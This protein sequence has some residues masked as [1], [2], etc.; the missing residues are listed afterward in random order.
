M[1]SDPNFMCSGL[2]TVAPFFGYLVFQFLPL[3]VLCLSFALFYQ[4]MPN[5]R[6][7]WQASLVGG[8]VGGTLWQLNNLLSVFYASRVVS[9]S[10]VYGSLGLVP[11]IMIG[12]YLSW[13]ILLFGAQVAY[14]FQNRRVY[15]QEKQLQ[16]FN[17]AGR[18][19]IGLRIMILA[20][21]AFQTGKISASTA[22][23]AEALGVPTQLTTQ[24]VQQLLEAGMLSQVNQ[25][26]TGFVPARPLADISCFDII[27][28]LRVGTG[29]D[30]L[31]D[32]DPLTDGNSLREELTKVRG[33]EL[34]VAGKMTLTQLASLQG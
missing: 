16:N 27:Q 5:T 9:N 20:A 31:K 1:P 3:V 19:F 25:A 30:P 21:R 28:A 4:T 13:M 10:Y 18:E 7:Q 33:A 29:D 22:Q 34:Q 24:I 15:Y 17:H 23:M 14:V 26:E 2:V 6:V 11:L 12:L 8:L 32:P